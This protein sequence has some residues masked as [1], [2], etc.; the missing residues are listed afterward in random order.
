M[1][2]ERFKKC[3]TGLRSNALILLASQRLTQCLFFRKQFDAVLGV[4][5]REEDWIRSPHSVNDLGYSLKGLTRL[6]VRI[7]V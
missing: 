7:S 6:F 1:S 5:V 3:V 2:V 4:D